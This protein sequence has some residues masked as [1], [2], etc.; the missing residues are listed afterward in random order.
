MTGTIK[1]S[2]SKLRSTATSFS[3]TANQIKTLTSNM[4]STVEGLS[5]AVWSGDA[6]NA[7]KRKFKQLDDD[8]A[9]LVKMINEHATDLNEMA[10]EYEAAENQN[11]NASNSL[12]GDVIV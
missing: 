2:T 8:I 9:K 10:R 3:N 4:T 5:G 11:I 7:Y 12:S 6:A 1:V